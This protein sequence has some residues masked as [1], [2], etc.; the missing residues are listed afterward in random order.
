MSLGAC[1]MEQEQSPELRPVVEDYI[2]TYQ[3]RSDWDKMLSFYSDSI[4]LKDLNFGLEFKGIE[5][6]KGFYDWPNPDFQKLSPDQKSLTVDELV[7]D[8]STAVIRGQF[9]PFYWKGEQQN[10]PGGFSI[11]LHFDKQQKIDQQLAYI[12][13]PASLLPQD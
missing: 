8:G 6:F 2:K 12:I 7:I 4:V 5:A 11:W 3:E 1:S 13:Y 10:W 9:Q